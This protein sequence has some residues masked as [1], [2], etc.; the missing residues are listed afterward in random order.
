MEG[1]TL[2]SAAGRFNQYNDVEIVI[3]DAR[4]AQEPV[5]GTF[6]L[7]EPEEFARGIATAFQAH[8]ER[9]RGKLVLSY[10]G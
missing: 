1:E 9:R 4:L 10:S 7:R 8:V 2:L 5:V 3:D 6:D